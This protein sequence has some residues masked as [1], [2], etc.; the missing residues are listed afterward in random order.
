MRRDCSRSKESA[1]KLLICEHPAGLIPPVRER[2][3]FHTGLLNSLVECHWRNA[4]MIAHMCARCTRN[5]GGRSSFLI[6]VRLLDDRSEVLFSSLSCAQLVSA[7]VGSRL[8]LIMRQLPD[9]KMVRHKRRGSKCPKR[10]SHIWDSPPITFI[11]FTVISL[12]SSN[13]EGQ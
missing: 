9:K 8:D 4:H 3:C 5:A 6:A 7:P 12:L 2:V 1:R 11:Y 13:R 10:K